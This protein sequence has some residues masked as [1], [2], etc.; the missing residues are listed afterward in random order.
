MS[1]VVLLVDILERKGLSN[2][3]VGEAECLMVTLQSS[4]LFF[5]DK[6]GVKDLKLLEAFKLFALIEEAGL[7]LNM[8]LL[9]SLIT[10]RLANM[11]ASMDFLWD[12]L[13]EDKT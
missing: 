5:R 3:M 2:A 9:A 10:P 7:S 1:R 11:L 6:R 12:L 8:D 4:S 13:S